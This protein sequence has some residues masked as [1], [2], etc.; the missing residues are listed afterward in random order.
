MGREERRVQGLD[1][2]DVGSC[3][4]RPMDEFAPPPHRLKLIE[5]APNQIEFAPT[6]VFDYVILNF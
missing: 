3:R 2:K 5:F 6:S 1:Y 4:I